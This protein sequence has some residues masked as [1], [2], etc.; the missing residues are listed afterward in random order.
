MLTDQQ[1]QEVVARPKTII[2][3]SPATG[4]HEEDRHRRCHL[5]LAALTDP[6]VKFQVFVRQSSEFMEGF[7]IGLRGKVGGL[8]SP[9][10]TL[11][12]YNGPHGESSTS[13][14]GHYSVPHIHRITAE[15]IASGSDRPR[16]KSREITTRYHTYEEAL[17]VFFQDIRVDN[18]EAYFSELR[19]LRL[20]N[21]H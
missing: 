11:I 7:S 6:A 9:T 21:G 3:K 16:E 19:Q 2:Q 5:E 8:G 1:I 14:D 18:Y 12:R 17:L 13:D 10:V 4:Y 20:F 15:A